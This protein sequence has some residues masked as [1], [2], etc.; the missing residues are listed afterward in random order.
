MVDVFELVDY[1]LEG[2]EVRLLEG[3]VVVED[4]EDEVLVL[5]D[6]VDE[7]VDGGDLLGEEVL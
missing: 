6:E 2:I 4:G 5:V 7:G 3:G 1:V